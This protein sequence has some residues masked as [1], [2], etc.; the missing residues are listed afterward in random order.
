MAAVPLADKVDVT[1]DVMSSWR[2]ASDGVTAQTEK[3]RKK[4]FEHWISYCQKLQMDP[5]LRNKSDTEICIA[6][7]AFAARVRKGSYGYGAQVKVGQVSKALAVISKTIELAG[8]T[9]PLYVEKG[10]FKTPIARML[11]GF[12][13]EDPPVVPQLAVPVEVPHAAYKA[14]YTTSCKIEKAKADLALIAFYYLLRVGEY[15]KP[16]YTVVNGVKRRTTR[17][18]QFS[19]GNI[20]FFKDDTLLKVVDENGKLLLSL[21]ELL[22]ATSATMKITNQKNGHMGETIHHECTGADTSP[23]KAL[24]RRVY[25]IIQDGGSK[26]SLLCDYYDQDSEQWSSITADQMRQLIKTTVT[27][28]DL[29]ARGI[30]AELVGS[31][32]LR[33]GGAMALKLHGIDDITI[34]KI[35]RWS[36]LTF[37]MYIHTQIAHLSAGISTAMSTSLPYVNIAA[38]RV[39]H[40]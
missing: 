32:S 29:K 38:V 2:A 22:E 24:A 37:T 33:S 19:I 10:V 21:D 13:R 5:F 23:V 40:Q 16:K 11:E 35:G 15:T 6:A 12:R 7:M 31:H 9:S 30:V 8:A 17:T 26:D 34:K 28:L 3:N 36:W 27:K 1:H 18:K 25:Q 39:G 4:Y 14:A 20:G